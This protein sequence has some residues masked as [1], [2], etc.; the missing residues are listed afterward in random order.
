MLKS[1]IFAA[2]I[3]GFVSLISVLFLNKFNG[4]I[5]P[6]DEIK[7]ALSGLRG[8]LSPSSTIGCR[9]FTQKDETIGQ[10]ANA[11]VPVSVVP[12]T[13]PRDTMLYVFNSDASDSMIRAVTN[14]RAG[15]W[16]VKSAHYYFLLTH[17]EGK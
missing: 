12:F 14:S 13:D 5:T 15:F 1:G 6:L 9:S 8:V 7:A 17:N 10:V 11:M 16:K 2:I 3:F 4:V